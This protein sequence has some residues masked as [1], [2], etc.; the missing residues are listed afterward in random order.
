MDHLNESLLS[1]WMDLSSVINNERI[2][3]RMPYNVAA[4]LHY[5]TR[6]N[7]EDVTASEL[8]AELRMQKSQMNRTLQYMEDHGMIIR[9]R[10]E[11]DK[12][13]VYIRLCDASLEPFLS[14]HQ[15]VIRYIG[16]VTDALGDEKTLQLISLIEEVIDIIKEKDPQ[17]KYINETT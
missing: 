5:L 14:Q 17:L 4:I 12:R 3:A 6:H 2:S 7:A 1:A 13:L 9:E 10:S 16:G 11:S 15:A 8:C